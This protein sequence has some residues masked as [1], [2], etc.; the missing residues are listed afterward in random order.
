MVDYSKKFKIECSKTQPNTEKNDIVYTISKI[1]FNTELP[2]AYAKVTSG[3]AY[4][5]ET[6]VHL[7]YD[8]LQYLQEELRKIAKMQNGK[9]TVNI[10]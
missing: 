4:R 8:E 1:Q 9:T 2:I 7:K 3:K 6:S 10:Y 5:L